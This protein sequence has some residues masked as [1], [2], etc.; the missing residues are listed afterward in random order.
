VRRAA[1]SYW[2]AAALGAAALGAVV[3]ALT[4]HSR[5]RHALQEIVQEHCVIDWIS[6]HDPAPCAQVVLP[7]PGHA[8]SGY[9]L[10]ADRKGGAHFLLIPTRTISGI[11]SPLLVEP[12]APNY[13]AFAWEARSHLADVVGHGVPRGAVG[14]A[15]NPPSARSQDQLHIHIECL[16]TAA[17]RAIDAAS[18]HFGTGWAVVRIGGVRFEA[19]RLMGEHLQQNPFEILAR[20]LPDSGRTPGDYTLLL[21]GRQFRDGPGFVLLAGTERAADLW[22]DSSCAAARAT[23]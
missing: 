12:D 17:M 1:A 5:S 7:D 20:N 13:F 2:A 19:R 11:E 22:L 4:A 21:A 18:D 8:D 23:P 3:F 9:A 10:L 14:L 16:N 6:R 15:V